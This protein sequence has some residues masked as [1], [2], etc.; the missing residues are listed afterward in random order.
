MARD[1]PTRVSEPTAAVSPYLPRGPRPKN[2]NVARIQQSFLQACKPNQVGSS[3]PPGNGLKLLIRLSRWPLVYGGPKRGGGRGCP[4]YLWRHNGSIDGKAAINRNFCTASIHAVNKCINS[5]FRAYF[6]PV[7]YQYVPSLLWASAMTRVA[8]TLDPCR[9]AVSPV[10]RTSHSKFE[11]F[12]PLNRAA[13]LIGWKLYRSRVALAEKRKKVRVQGTS[14]DFSG[15]FPVNFGALGMHGVG[16][17]HQLYS[18]QR[19]FS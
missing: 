6:W 7:Y 9:T 13:F 17:V 12:S 3:A 10:L 8:P 2:K 5:C 18:S 16:V 15:V 11:W 1:S 4:M 14:R 19:F